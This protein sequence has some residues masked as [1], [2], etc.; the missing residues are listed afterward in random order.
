MFRTDGR[1][2][3]SNSESHKLSGQVLV[4][5]VTG[6]VG[7]GTQ[8]TGNP[9]NQESLQTQVTAGCTPPIVGRSTESA[10]FL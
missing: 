3:G 10:L 1:P 6:K 5:A 7:P 2:T 4:N 9:Q 8:V